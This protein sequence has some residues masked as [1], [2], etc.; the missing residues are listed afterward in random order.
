V[1]QLSKDKYE[2][3]EWR[4]G[5]SPESV[6]KLEGVEVLIKKGI[7]EEIITEN[8]NAFQKLKGIRFLSET[9][10]EHLGNELLL[11]LTQ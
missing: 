3:Y 5:R 10:L 9:I 2:T 6:L 8:K 11:K 4:F 1:I 7:I